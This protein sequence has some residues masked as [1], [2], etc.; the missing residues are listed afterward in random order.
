MLKRSFV[1]LALALPLALPGAALSTPPAETYQVDVVHSS[2]IFRIKHLDVSYFYGFF[3]QV[4]GQVVH[5]AGNPS[6]SSVS[7]TIPA[8]SVYTNNRARDEHLK[9][10]DFFNVEQFPNITFESTSV[11]AGEGDGDL[12]VT[13]DLTLHGVTRELTVDVFFHGARDTGERFGHRAGWEA[14]F[15]INRSD[16]EMNAMVGSLLGDEVNFTVSLEG[17]RR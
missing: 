6:N 15:S 2:A 8:A 4:T 16:F 17:I 9:G 1:L 10:P 3:T 13:G 11:A 5:D 7:I 14:T 12:R